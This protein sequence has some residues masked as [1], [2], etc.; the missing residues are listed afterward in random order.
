VAGNPC[1]DY[2]GHIAFQALVSGGGTNSTNNS[3][4]WL[5]T[6]AGTGSLIAQTGK[7][8]AAGP[9]ASVSGAA[10]STLSDPLLSK[11]MVAFYAKLT[12]GLGGVA[13][14]NAA[15]IWTQTTGTPTLGVSTGTVPPNLSTATLAAISQFGL[16]EDDATPFVGT[17]SGKSFTPSNNRRLWIPDK[18]AALTP[19]ASSANSYAALVPLAF[20]GGQGRS[21]DVVNNYA[22][23]LLKKPTDGAATE[24]DL[25]TPSSTTGFSVTPVIEVPGPKQTVSAINDAPGV[26]G[27]TVASLG[28]PAVDSN[29]SLAFKFTMKGSGVA[30]DN[31]T[32][33]AVVNTSGTAT[34]LARTGVGSAPGTSGALYAALSDPVL[35]PNTTSKDAVA[36]VASLAPGIG[37]TVKNGSNGQGIWHNANNTSAMTL[38]ARKGGPAPGGGT[39]SGFSEIALTDDGTII[40]QATI[41]GVS[42]TASQAICYGYGSSTFLVARTGAGVIV[43]TSAKTIKSLKIFPISTYCMGQSRSFSHSNDDFVYTAVFTD[44]TWAIYVLHFS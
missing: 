9:G 36:F 25:A 22:A 43:G 39:F 41:S 23:F 4:I 32:G 21:V 5:Y 7:G 8:S 30:A 13:A 24:I 38:L 2:L 29:G 12:P 31:N 28:E 17:V 35:A 33:L 19:V 1:I 18:T 42:A 37:D 6:A 44:G 16:N 3:G 10:F 14:A 34:L 11:D 40:F 26:T 27:A 20:V 15:G